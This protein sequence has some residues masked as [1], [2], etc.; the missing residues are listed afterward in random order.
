MN[1]YSID[2]AN[3]AAELNQKEIYPEW[4][5]TEKFY[6]CDD[7]YRSLSEGKVFRLK[8]FRKKPEGK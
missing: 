1:T 6:N 8:W 7:F 5:K 3:E 4:V 2:Y